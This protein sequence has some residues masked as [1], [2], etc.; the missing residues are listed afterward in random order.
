MLRFRYT[1][2]TCIYC[3]AYTCAAAACMGFLL[4]WMKPQQWPNLFASAWG[5]FWCEKGVSCPAATL[6]QPKTPNSSTPHA[7]LA[8]AG[9]CCRDMA[10]AQ[11]HDSLLLLMSTHSV[12]NNPNSHSKNLWPNRLISMKKL[13]PRK[14]RVRGSV[15][16]SM[17]RSNHTQKFRP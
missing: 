8:T 6:L 1:R 15:Q 16:R 9:K 3:A 5:K 7:T 11:T 17:V 4:P 14:D 2:L 10:P 13:F 12:E